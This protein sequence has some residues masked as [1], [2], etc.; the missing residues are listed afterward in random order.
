MTTIFVI[1][2]RGLEAIAADELREIPTVSIHQ[3]GYRHIRAA[4]DAAQIGALVGL[5][6]ADDVFLHLADW[7]GVG[8]TRDTLTRLREWAARL[9]LPA[10]AEAITALRPV[11]RPPR[12]SISAN[13]VGKRNYTADEI[14]AAVAGGIRAWQYTED[15]READYN[16][17]LFIEHET[18]LVGLRLT[19]YP[20]HD[21]LGKA[22]Q[23]PGSLKATVAAAML[24]LA[25]VHPGHI[26]LDPFCG[27][28]T[29][30]ME[31][32]AMGA[33]PLGGDV[34]VPAAA[35]A[36]V[37][38]DDG[39]R[40]GGSRTA[41]TREWCICQWDARRLPLADE[42][43]DAVVSNLPWGRQIQPDADLQALYQQASRD[44]ERV[45]RTGGRAVF[46]TTW[47]EWLTFERL[48]LTESWTISLF[49]QQPTIAVFDG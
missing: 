27:A 18:A 8:H 9:D 43:V 42:S 30:L 26:L 29:I 31:A 36:R 40:R 25:G 23:R 16:L 45:L 3:T 35:A 15:D 49:G 24:R 28:G 6:T 7:Q 44:S 47:P 39:Q 32:A 41:P 1:T 22:A 2:A 21:R 10:A 19:R 38:M 20:L 11:S 4:L 46:L 13:F 33:V 14:K 37:N 12:Y 17:R 48:R 34:V 5:R